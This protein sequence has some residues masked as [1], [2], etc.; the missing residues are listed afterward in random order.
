MHASPSTKDGLIFSVSGPTNRRVQGFFARIRARQR[1]L[2]KYGLIIALIAFAAGLVVALNSVDLL[3]IKLPFLLAYALVLV[4]LGFVLQCCELRLLAKAGNASLSWHEAIEVVIY[5]K[6]AT[7]L[8]VPGGFMTRVAAL[9]VKGVPVA[10]SSLIILLFT[11]I[12]GTIAFTYAAIWLA[13]HPLAVGFLFVALA[14]LMT[15]MI[16]ATRVKVRWSIIAQEVGLRILGVALETI[17][18]VCAFASIGVSAEVQQ[19][20]VMVVASFVGLLVNIVPA[21][22]GIKEGVIALLSPYVGIAPA[23]GFLAAALTRVIDFAWMGLLAI[24]QI[25]RAR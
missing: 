21:G 10:K 13:P 22:I 9:K 25:W 6:A 14:G 7:L 12:F 24:L 16:L 20:G 15:C 19:T 2:R 8:P 4:P 17:G 5:S 11:G 3:R 1:E 18:L 23:L